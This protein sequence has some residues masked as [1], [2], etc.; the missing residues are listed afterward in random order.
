MFLWDTHVATTILKPKEKLIV[1]LTQCSLSVIGDR[2]SGHV[3]TIRIYESSKNWGWDIK[4]VALSITSHYIVKSQLIG[5]DPIQTGTQ[6]LKQNRTQLLLS[7]WAQEILILVITSGRR[8]YAFSF[9][10]LLLNQR[11]LQEINNYYEFWLIK[12]FNHRSDQ[13]PRVPK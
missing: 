10:Q 3:E 5:T 7:H 1:K 8:K 4:Y 2:A 9:Q 6:P 13:I 11:L 12:A